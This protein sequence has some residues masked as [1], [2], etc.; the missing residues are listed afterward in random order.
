MDI[1]Y[2]KKQD[3][4]ILI[5]VAIKVS[6]L[7]VCGGGIVCNG[8]QPPFKDTIPFFLPSPLKS[9]NDA[10]PPFKAILPPLYICFS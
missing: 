8:V 7:C 9:A 3:M 4:Q 10:S 5:M 6:F 1:D 2:I